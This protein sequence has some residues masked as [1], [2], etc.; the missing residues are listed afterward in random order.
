MA[1]I[2]FISP[3]NILLKIADIFQPRESAAPS[4]VF[5]L[6]SNSPKNAQNSYAESNNPINPMPK[7]K[8]NISLDDLKV[9][10][11]ALLQYRRNLAKIG[12]NE[13]A[14]GVARIDKQFYELI[15]EI[16]AKMQPDEDFSKVAA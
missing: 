15:N 4:G 5:Q 2:S 10:S 8:L 9:I 14:E 16:E 3:K 12:E 1:T 6:R 13:K 11:T 7:T